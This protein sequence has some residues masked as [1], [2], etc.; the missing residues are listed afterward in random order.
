M[1]TFSISVCLLTLLLA[2]S[3]KLASEPF[4]YKYEITGNSKTASEIYDLYTYKERLI[5]IYDKNFLALSEKKREVKLIND[6]DLFNMINMNNNCR[7][8]Y[9]SGTIVVLIGEAKGMTITG[10]LRSNSC[11]ET[12]IRT[13]IFIFDIFNK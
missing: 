2:G 9:V 7:S 6:I 8:Y 11:D 13:K 3:S 12:V 1:K 10:D 5:D 4:K